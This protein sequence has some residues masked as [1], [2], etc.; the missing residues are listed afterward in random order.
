MSHWCDGDIKREA[1][2]WKHEQLEEDSMNIT[3]VRSNAT[4]NMLA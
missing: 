3:E 4:S 1:L 2:P